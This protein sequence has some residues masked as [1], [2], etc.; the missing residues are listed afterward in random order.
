[1]RLAARIHRV[2]PSLQDR[3]PAG[4]DPAHGLA[5]DAVADQRARYG[6]NT[7]L[8][9]VSGGWKRLLQDTLRDPMLWFLLLKN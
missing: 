4:F 3:L 9:P 7:I 6:H 2:T 5:P 8:A 1:M